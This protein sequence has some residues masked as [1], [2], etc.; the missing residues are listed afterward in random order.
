MAWLFEGVTDY[1]AH[2]TTYQSGVIDLSSWKNKYNRIL[3]RHYL[4]LVKNKSNEH[5]IRH[6][7]EKIPFMKNYPTT[8]GK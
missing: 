7:D 5:I 1:Y 2:K 6:F 3:A 4:S 8:E